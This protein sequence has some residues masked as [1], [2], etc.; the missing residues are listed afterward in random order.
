MSWCPQMVK[1]AYL[2]MARPI[3]LLPSMLLVIFGAWV[4]ASHFR[5]CLRILL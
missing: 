1:E 2:S 5:S 4:R 3:N